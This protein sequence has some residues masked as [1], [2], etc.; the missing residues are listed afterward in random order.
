MIIIGSKKIST[1]IFL[2][3]LSGCT[4]LAFRLIAREYGAKFCFFEMVD[5]NSLKYHS[6]SV[7]DILK[8][9]EDDL[10]IAAQLVGSDPEAMVDGAKNLID[11][12]DLSFIDIN[13]ACPVPKITKKKAGAHLIKEP[14]KLYKIVKAM[15]SSLALPV[16]VKLRIG[17]DKED[18]DHIV[19]IAKNCQ[20]N[21]AAALFVHGRTKAKGYTGEVNYKSIKVIKESVDIPV[22]GSGNVFDPQLAKKMLDSTGCDGVMI[23]RGALGNP[24]IFKRIEQ[25]LNNGKLL[26][27]PDIS[28]RMTA[29]LSH[30]AYIKQFKGFGPGGRIGEMRKVAIWHLKSFPNASVYRKG[31]VDA[32]SYDDLL[33]L[34][35]SILD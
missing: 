30:L 34:L 7:E 26:P 19:Q 25:Y 22:F 1:N 9:N 32:E 5:C 23:A 15:A 14:K 10:P 16:T 28:Q 2:A 12:F 31:V 18:N 17:Y 21:G 6:K 33:R 4:D 27:E 35:D 8:T 29:L 13:A 20:K 11:R 3:P 24:W